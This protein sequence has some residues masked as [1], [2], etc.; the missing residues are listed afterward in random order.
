MWEKMLS[1]SL[2]S[3]SPVKAARF[4]SCRGKLSQ[5]TPGVGGLDLSQQGDK[6]VSQGL[7]PSP[8]PATLGTSAQEAFHLPREGGTRAARDGTLAIGLERAN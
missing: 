3:S 8:P 2:L 6:A 5:R 4:M 7:P 1:P